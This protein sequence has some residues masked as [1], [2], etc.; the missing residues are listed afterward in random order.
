MARKEFNLL[1]KK[2]IKRFYE[3]VDKEEQERITD[4]LE[5]IKKRLVDFS[6]KNKISDDDMIKWRYDPKT[7]KL[8]VKMDNDERFV[9]DC[10]W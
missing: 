4:S 9:F 8:D 10:Y 5:W 2:D 1:S 3:S 6:K 7:K